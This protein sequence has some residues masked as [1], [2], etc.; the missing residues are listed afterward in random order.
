MTTPAPTPDSGPETPLAAEPQDFSLV[1]GGPL[2][3]LFLRTHLSGSAL[4][5]LRR[6]MSVLALLAWA[7]LLVLSMLEG[8]AWGDGVRLPFLFDADVHL[9]LLLALPLFIAAELVV[10]R[11]L[12]LVVRQFVVRGVLPQSARAGFDAAIASAA[13]LRNSVVAEVLLL[14]FVYTVGIA[15]L[16]R[17]HGALDL[18]SW[19]RVEVAGV[20]QPTLAG[21]WFACVSLPLFQFILLRWYFR[22]F[23]WTR[24]L[25]RISRLDF[26]LVPTHPDRAGGLG[27]LAVV[28]YPFALLLL[29]QGVMLAGLMANRIFY[30]GSKLL[31]FKLE[32]IALVAVMLIVV[33]GPLLVFTPRLLRTK[34]AGLS[35]YGGLAQG[36]VREF[37]RKWLRGGAPPA[38]PLLG[39]ADLQSL[40]DLGNSYEIV[41]GMRAVV[42]TRETVLQ[43]AVMVLLPVAPLVLTMIPLGELVDRLLKVL[44]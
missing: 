33:L 5:L 14:A 21:W 35:E 39:S 24:F 12:S 40:A 29:G 9:R 17:N 25:W 10:H 7:P 38:E 1:L 30:A 16:W 44:F 23:V 22:L 43:L 11:R 13:R 6:R 15:F 27:F 42:F 41:K 34:R 26:Q 18:T 28:S 32:L 19:Y 8:H 37:D 36:Y 2:F 3:Q 4:E 20:R 31:D